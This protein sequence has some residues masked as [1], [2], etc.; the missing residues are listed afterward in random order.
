MQELL[1]T[2]RHFTYISGYGKYMLLYEGSHLSIKELRR[3]NNWQL[4]SSFRDG[5][6]IALL[7]W[8]QSNSP[9]FF[10]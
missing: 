7:S 1:V 10:R 4:A 2:S 8:V 5:E 3:K 9:G 6:T